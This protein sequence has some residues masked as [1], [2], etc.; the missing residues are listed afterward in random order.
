MSEKDGSKKIGS[1]Y[2]TE[3]QIDQSQWPIVHWTPLL[4]A[5][6]RNDEI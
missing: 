4:A 5:I 6:T 1:S 2:E 3:K